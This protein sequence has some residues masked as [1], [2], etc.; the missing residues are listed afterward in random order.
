M[1]LVLL[2]GFF[3]RAYDSPGH[4]KTAP[5]TILKAIR[6]DNKQLNLLCEYIILPPDKSADAVSTYIINYSEPQTGNPLYLRISAVFMYSFL[7]ERRIDFPPS[8]FL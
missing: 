5:S 2:A 1:N 7:R 4:T 8:E 6:R 3:F